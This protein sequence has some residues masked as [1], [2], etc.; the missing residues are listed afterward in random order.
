MRQHKAQGQPGE[1]KYCLSLT[2]LGESFPLGL[3]QHRVLPHD[4]EHLPAHCQE[5]DPLLGLQGTLMAQ[6]GD[7]AKQLCQGAWG[8]DPD[9]PLQPSPWQSLAD[10]WLKPGFSRIYLKSLTAKCPNETG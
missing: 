1:K 3:T 6:G 7:L 2:F 8:S 10:I 9:L 4:P 5:E